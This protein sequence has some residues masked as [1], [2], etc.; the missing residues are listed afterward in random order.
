MMEA[1]ALGV[2]CS[3]VWSVLAFIVLNHLPDGSGSNRERVC[4]VSD[5]AVCMLSKSAGIDGV[6]T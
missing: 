3:S 4:A 2:S 6:Q 1:I 5:Y